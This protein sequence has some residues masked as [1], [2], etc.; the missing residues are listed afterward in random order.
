MSDFAASINKSKKNISVSENSTIK[1]DDKIYNFNLKKLG[2]FSYLLNLN[3]KF[4]EITARQ[5]DEEKYTIVVNGSLFEIEIRTLLQEK[6]LKLLE[7]KKSS[8]RKLEIK[9]PMPGMILKVN[10]KSGD[11]VSS[12]E[13]VIILEA[14]KMENELRAP[15]SGIIKDVFVNEG[16]AVDK[17]LK[18]FSIET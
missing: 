4:Y 15:V 7:Q 18:L 16:S 1:V 8:N 14:M 11:K 3:N 5:I 10:K 2:E 6:A 17:G 9:A 12:G 13:P